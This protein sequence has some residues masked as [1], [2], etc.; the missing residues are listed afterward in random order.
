MNKDKV[1]KVLNFLPAIIS[2]V[3]III[4]IVV[5]TD[6]AK[7]YTDLRYYDQFIQL[8]GGGVGMSAYDYHTAYRDWYNHT[9]Y[10]DIIVK[11]GKLQYQEPDTVDAYDLDPVDFG[12][13]TSGV[14]LSSDTKE[15]CV[16]TANIEFKNNGTDYGH[17]SISQI[18]NKDG[19][20][21]SLD[22]D[23]RVVPGT[24]GDDKVYTLISAPNITFY[25]HKS[26]GSILRVVCT[27]EDN[28][29]SNGYYQ[30]IMPT[31]R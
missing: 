30:L 29:F 22:D 19:T 4:T 17:I 15:K 26:N 20:V 21:S 12:H 31:D 2:I 24:T 27:D 7:S 11:D 23:F 10:N 8:V 28:I 13:L 1:F 18:D 25:Y 9:D 6:I 16:K 5:A 3:T 14:Y